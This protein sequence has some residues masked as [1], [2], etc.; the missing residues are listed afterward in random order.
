MKRC[1]NY[2]IFCYVFCYQANHIVLFEF[3]RMIPESPRWLL[4]Q[5][6]VKTAKEVLIGAAKMNR[7][8]INDMDNKI[9]DIVTAS[10][11]VH[12]ESSILMLIF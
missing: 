7:R 9:E 10:N 4:A 8:K 5:G 11:E 2:I 6:K 12:F 1:E 3:H